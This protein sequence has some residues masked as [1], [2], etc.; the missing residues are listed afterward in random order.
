MDHPGQVQHQGA[1]GPLGKGLPGLRVAQI[2]RDHLDA[3]VLELPGRLVRAD[4]AAHPAA[5][6]AH[7]AQLGHALAQRPRH[8]ATEPA[9]SAGDQDQGIVDQ[10]FRHLDP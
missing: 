8:P 3:Q 5:A 9:G 1:L 7:L 10:V 2:A 4:Q 6:G